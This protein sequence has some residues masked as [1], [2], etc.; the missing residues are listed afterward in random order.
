MVTLEVMSLASGHLYTVTLISVQSRGQD[1]FFLLT[2]FSWALSVCANRSS[3]SS[4]L[5]EVCLQAAGHTEDAVLPRP[6]CQTTASIIIFQ[7]L[8]GRIFRLGAFP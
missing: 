4:R 1:R 3:S 6:G 8:T 5:N 2:L 7:L